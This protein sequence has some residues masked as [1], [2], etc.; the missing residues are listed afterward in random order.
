MSDEANEA[1]EIDAPATQIDEQ[2]EQ[3]QPP[4]SA[5]DTNEQ[6]DTGEDDQEHRLPK[7]VQKRI[8][9]LTREKYR[10][11]AQLE[12]MQQA[13]KQPETQRQPQQQ[14]EGAP[15]PDKFSSYEDYLEAKAE[16]KAEQK[17]S[18]VLNRQREESQKQSA[19]AKN[20]EMQRS[21]EKRVSDAMGTYD[22]FEEVALSPDVPVTESMM[23]AILRAEKGADVAYFL[24]KNPEIASQLSRMDPVSVAIR[25]GEIAATVVRPAAKKTTSAPPP[26]S[27]VGSRSG[28]PQK[29]PDK[30]SIDEWTRWRND[31]IKTRK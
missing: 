30:M 17:V 9:R 15:T 4:E 20:A 10:L 22:D 1:Q 16:W 26:I 6:P 14:A 7:G 29:D 18:E 8:D 28:A 12:V 2:G 24:G 5:P 19:N 31:Q 11:Q 25:I 21:W 3:P 13:P 23:Q 27:P